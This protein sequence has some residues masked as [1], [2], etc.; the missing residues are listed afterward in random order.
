VI[1]DGMMTMT[2]G[3]A[4]TAAAAVSRNS[5]VISGTDNAREV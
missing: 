5:M 2:A 3:M 1:N 4:H